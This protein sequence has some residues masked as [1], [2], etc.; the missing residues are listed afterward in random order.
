MMGQQGYQL[1]IKHKTKE[2]FQS[3]TILSCYIWMLKNDKVDLNLLEIFAATK[4]KYIIK[5]G[6]KLRNAEMIKIFKV[7]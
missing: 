6:C 5:N 2:Q 3:S 7:K 4:N 1:K